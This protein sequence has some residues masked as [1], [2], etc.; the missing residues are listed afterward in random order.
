VQWLMVDD[1]LSMSP[2]QIKAFTDAYSG[3]NRPR[4]A[5]DG[6]AVTIDTPPR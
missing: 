2:A 5:L 4:Q 1:P 6:R 3:N